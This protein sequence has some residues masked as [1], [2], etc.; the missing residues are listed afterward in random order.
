[1]PCCRITQAEDASSSCLSAKRS[2]DSDEDCLN[3]LIYLHRTCTPSSTCQ[4]QCKTAV[5]NLHQLPLGRRLLGTDLSCLAGV[6]DELAKC[7]LLPTSRPLHCT[8]A[9]SVCEQEVECARLKTEWM[10][11]CETRV[12][13]RRHGAAHPRV[14]V[15][16]HVLGRVSAAVRGTDVARLGL[17][18][19]R[20]HLLDARRVV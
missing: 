4:A 2:C 1:M 10:T 20:L 11:D 6:R 17:G 18:T 16:R 3:R 13:V 8:L 19:P 12:Q 14:T 15:E 9:Q 7:Q 5:L